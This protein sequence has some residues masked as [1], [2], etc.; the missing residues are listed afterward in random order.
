MAVGITVKLSEIQRSFFQ[1]LFETMTQRTPFFPGA[2][3]LRAGGFAI[4]YT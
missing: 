1:K 3:I 4:M 2:Q